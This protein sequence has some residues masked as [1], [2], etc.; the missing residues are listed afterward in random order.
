M[1]KSLWENLQNCRRSSKK[2][3]KYL[4]LV[5]GKYIFLLFFLKIFNNGQFFFQAVKSNKEINLINVFTVLTLSI[6]IITVDSGDKRRTRLLHLSQF[7]IAI[8]A[9]EN[10]DK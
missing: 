2:S 3:Q 4:S 6:A 7:S 1:L 10:S 8:I 9:I 5:Q